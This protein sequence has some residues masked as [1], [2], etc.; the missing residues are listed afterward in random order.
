MTVN[1]I[2]CPSCKSLVLPDTAQ[3]PNCHY[4]FDEKRVPSDFVPT[5]HVV[6]SSEEEVPCPGCNELVRKGLV[7]C[8]NCGTF[9]Q[10]DIAESYRRMQVSPPKVIYSQ[11]HETPADAG[12]FSGVLT[13]SGRLIEKPNS[14]EQGAGEDEAD[15]EVSVEMG[16]DLDEGDFD[17]GTADPPA[18]QN[19][20]VESAPIFALKSEPEVPEAKAAERPAAG[21]GG[22]AKPVKE[23][24]PAAKEAA[25]A[26]DAK[27][28]K[29]DSRPEFSNEFENRFG[30]EDPAAATGD[31][32]L[33]V[34]LAEE[35]ETG[36]RRRGQKHAEGKVKAGFRVYCP[37]GHCIEVQ[38]RHRGQTGRCPRCRELYYVPAGNWDEEKAQ[39]EDKAQKAAAIAA[40]V[41]SQG[42]GEKPA[43]I[44]AGEYTRWMLDSHFHALDLTKLKLKP[45]SLLKDFQSADVGFA[46]D[47]ILIVLLMKKGGLFGGGDKKKLSTR[48][49]V[50]DHLSKGK[51][52]EDLPAGGHF[53]FAAATVPQLRIVQPIVSAEHSMFAG[54]PVFGEARIAVRLPKVDEKAD[55][56]FLSFTLSEFRRF[57]KILEEF[58][59]LRGFGAES[60]VPLEDVVTERYC[61]FSDQPL[62]ILENLEYYK[63]DPGFTLHVIGHKCAGCGLVV[64]EESRAK[65]NI[66]GK[67]G[68]KI[69]KAKCPKCQK[70]FGDLPLYSLDGPAA[71]P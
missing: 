44:S 39:E 38:E 19:E 48:E 68:K 11:V 20:I 16:P 4:V 52:R 3:C 23:P 65:E 63:N 51:S 31:V 29:T 56:Q 49:A 2:A 40:A 25:P 9:M 53:F 8:W 21:T 13:E 66:G 58:Y 5:E 54:V 59:S 24:K 37:N 42:V 45:G 50:L 41:N 69:A 6:E 64:S 26:A 14:L 47:G 22:A 46:P 10:Q 12:A 33:R 71:A 32:L 15:F 34:A 18:A 55:P 70:P 30:V 7:R 36:G 35:A 62:R 17:L 60:N 67:D 43:E 27:K 28:S 61:H 57:S 1:I